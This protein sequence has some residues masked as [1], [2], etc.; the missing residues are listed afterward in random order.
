MYAFAPF[1]GSPRAVRLGQVTQTVAKAIVD[2]A[3][4]ATRRL[5]QDE[6]T[7]L[8]EALIGGLPFAA[9]S[10]LAFVGTSYLVPPERRK[11]KFAGY[12]AAAGLL[13]AGALWTFWK[14]SEETVPPAAPSKPGPFAQTAR[15]AAQAIVQ[16]AEPKIKAI[17]DEERARIADSLLAALPFWTGAGAAFI[18]AFFLVPPDAPVAKAAAYGA[19]TLLWAMGAW[20]GLD[21]EKG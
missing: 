8:A 17:V 3:E 7:R 2:Q 14:I 5:I 15:D 9:G 12:A 10:A 4:P 11:L 19:A 1:L 20:A 13:G 21:K 16:E 18:G 6:R